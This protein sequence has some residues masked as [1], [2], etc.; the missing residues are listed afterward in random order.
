MY[1][2]ISKSRN[3]KN[4][5]SLSRIRRSG[6]L[7]ESSGGG[8]GVVFYVDGSDCRI[9]S[10]VVAAE[11]IY[12]SGVQIDIPE[13]PGTFIEDQKSDLNGELYTKAIIRDTGLDYS[14]GACQ[15]FEI[16]GYRGSSGWY[17]PSLGEG[18]LI[19]SRFSQIQPGLLALG[20]TFTTGGYNNGGYWTSSENYT[21]PAI[22]ANSFNLDGTF[23]MGNKTVGGSGTHHWLRSVIPVCRI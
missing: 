19:G 22:Y 7:P 3:R 13:I 2:T 16:N 17:Q 20:S 11:Q 10:P 5:H 14:A 9:V 21:D 1:K 18:Y 6:C 4:I 8:V 23:N 12:W 15:K